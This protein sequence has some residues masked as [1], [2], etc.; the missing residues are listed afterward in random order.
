MK[1]TKE[2]LKNLIAE[3]LRALSELDV[4]GPSFGT[5]T[6]PSSQPIKPKVDSADVRALKAVA[7][8]R[9]SEIDMALNSLSFEQ[10]KRLKDI[11]SALSIKADF[12]DPNAPTVYSRGG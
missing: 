2:K 3:E 10:K 9:L 1:L 11:F 5:Y 8:M 4:M 12:V 7:N 6:E